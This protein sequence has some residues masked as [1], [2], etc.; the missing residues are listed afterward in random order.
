MR[1]TARRQPDDM[2]CAC[3][4]RRSTTIVFGKL[5]LGSGNGA[6][7]FRSGRSA[8]AV[9]GPARLVDSDRAPRREV[10]VDVEVDVVRVLGLDPGGH[11]GAAQEGRSN[12]GGYPT[13]VRLSVSSHRFSSHS[14]EMR[15][16]VRRRSP[17]VARASSV[18]LTFAWVSPRGTVSVRTP[19]LTRMEKNVKIA[20]RAY[21]R[22]RGNGVT[23]RGERRISFLTKEEVERF[24]AA[25]PRDRARDRALFDLIYRYGLR[26]SEAAGLRLD[27]LS[28]GRIWV[29][30]LKGGVSA[31]YQIHPAT[32]RL[33]WAY[34]AVRGPSV[35]PYLFVSRQSRALPLSASPHSSPLP[36]SLLPL[37]T[38]PGP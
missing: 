10:V 5:R 12:S 4:A 11:K 26:R 8:P 18:V 13:P 3:T 31:D 17:R 35:S 22:K 15:C 27:G 37:L 23:D 38:S 19:E 33:L 7:C 32:R 1:C 16:G 14:V 20:R 36:L 34:L 25:I 9:P 28:D 2:R 6:R 29:A 24:F 30:R 21:R